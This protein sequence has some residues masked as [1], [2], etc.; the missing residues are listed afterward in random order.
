[1]Y[2]VLTGP[3]AL[4]FSQL[5]TICA[6]HSRT[7]PVRFALVALFYAITTRLT[8]T[9]PFEGS[10][11]SPTWFPTGV[12]LFLLAWWSPKFWPAVFIAG[13]LLPEQPFRAMDLLMSLANQR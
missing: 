1:M 4:N 7:Y 10:G 9:I 6:K 11:L 12:A 3:P 2:V 13:T 8:Q 5:T